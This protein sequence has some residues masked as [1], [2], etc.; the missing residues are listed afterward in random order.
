MNS[1]PSKLIHL[2]YLHPNT[3]VT[4]LVWDDTYPALLLYTYQIIGIATGGIRDEHNSCSDFDSIL[5]GICYSCI[6]YPTD[7]RDHMILQIFT[8]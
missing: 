3:N 6:T 7:C 4:M 5:H 2:I 1:D 8:L